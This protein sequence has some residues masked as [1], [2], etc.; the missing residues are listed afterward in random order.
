M[1]KD[2]PASK[3]EL[4][5]YERALLEHALGASSTTLDARLQ[6]LRDQAL[7]EYVNWLTGR[8]RFNSV[9][10]L[11]TFRILHLFLDI[12]G[13]VPTV[14]VLVGDI[15]MSAG[16]AQSLLNRLRYGEARKLRALAVDQAARALSE[17]LASAE[18]NSNRKTVWVTP[19]VLDI[20]LDAAGTI[21]RSPAEHDQGKKWA[22]AEFP[23]YVR[24]RAVAQVTTT[25]GMWEYILG[26]LT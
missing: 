10:E 9:S 20:V 24:Q 3:L 8:R 26:E 12:R 19:E 15:G 1:A 16:R 5:H 4:S 18:V 17:Q 7:G 21:M 6:I 22:G 13:E 25:V 23:T 11:E 14:D 2:D